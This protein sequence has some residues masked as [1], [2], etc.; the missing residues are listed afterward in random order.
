MRMPSF[1]TLITAIKRHLLPVS[2]TGMISGV[3]LFLYTFS[4]TYRTAQPDVVMANDSVV[5]VEPECCQVEVTGAVN[6]PG[7]YTLMRGQNTQDALLA[8]GGFRQDADAEFV[9]KKLDLDTEIQGSQKL[10]IPA[11][12]DKN[13]ISEAKMEDTS[14]VSV[15]TA[16]LQVLDTL[17]YVGAKT[18]QKIVD[19][20]P[21]H[22]IEDFFSRISFSESRQTE[23]RELIQL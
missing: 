4:L 17:P 23:L 11:A 15:N 7:V 8:A 20:R 10:F 5:Q 16:T 14:R 12:M 21:F 6:S 1:F 19:G 3:L 18:A 2:L 9:I 22:S 13:E